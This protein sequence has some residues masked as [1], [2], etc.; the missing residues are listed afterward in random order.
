MLQKFTTKELIIIALF[1]SLIFVICLL[2]V[3]IINSVLGFQTAG[4]GVVFFIQPALAIL[5]AYII[6]KK[7]VFPIILTLYAVL[8]IP[9]SLIGAG[10]GVL[11]VIPYLVGSLSAEPFVRKYT[12]KTAALAGGFFNL[13][14]FL[15][16]LPLFVLL[17]VPG[18]EKIISLALVAVVGMTIIGA[19]GGLFG[20]WIFNRIKD[21]PFTKQLQN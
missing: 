18:T 19:L 5:A 4:I 10:L 6:K 1:S 11:K 14:S 12:N 13:I 21:K 17:G 16:L 3:P 15:I 20:I 7:F 2:M 8:A 9:T